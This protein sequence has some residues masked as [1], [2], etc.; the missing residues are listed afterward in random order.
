[1]CDHPN[2]YSEFI[3]IRDESGHPEDALLV[4]SCEDCG[5]RWEE[6]TESTERILET[7]RP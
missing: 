3:V 2:T 7:I 5:E 1:M 6:R 4:T